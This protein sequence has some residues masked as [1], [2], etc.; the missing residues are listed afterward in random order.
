MGDSAG[1]EGSPVEGRWTGT[2]VSTLSGVDVAGDGG[3]EGGSS[4]ISEGA[5]G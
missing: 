4:G 3:G 2:L 5:G 1:I